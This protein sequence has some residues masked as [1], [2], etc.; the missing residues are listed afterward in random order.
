MKRS[1]KKLLGIAAALLL[2]LAVYAAMN[3]LIDPFGLFGD[4][5]FNWYGYNETNNPQMAKI[6]WLEKY[7]GGFDSYVIGSP[8]ASSLNA[9]ELNEYLD[10]SF[11]NLFT[12]SSSMKDYRD[13]TVY[14]L[15]NH[16][17]KNLVLNLNLSEAGVPDSGDGDIHYRKHAKVTGENPALFYM[18]YAF[19]S[20]RYAIDK[21][22]SC[23][24]DTLLPQTFDLFDAATGCYDRRIENVEKIG[25]PAVYLEEHAGA[26]EYYGGPSVQELPCLDECIQY[27]TE[28][29]DLCREKGVNLLVLCT[30][31]YITQLEAYGTEALARYKTALAQT[32][33]F[34][35]FSST[36]LSCDSRYFYDTFHFRDAVGTMVLAEVF[37]NDAVYR[38]DG[39]G[40][41]ITAGNNKEASR[42]P[43]QD[44]HHTQDVP[45]LMYHHFSE[46]TEGAVKPEE[47]ESH[48]QALSGAGY[49]PVFFQDL[50]DYVYHGI[51]LPEKPVCITFDDGYLSNYEIA[52]PLLELYG[53]KATIFAIGCSV[54][55]EEFYK[56]TEFR[57][58]PHFSYGQAREMTA[59]GAIDIQSHTYD[60]HQW[61][62]F[63]TGNEIR[64]SALPLP[65]ETEEAYAAALSADMTFYNRLRQQELNGDFCALAYPGGFYNTLTE[66]LIHEN[67]IP[68]T[69]SIKTDCRNVLVR[70]LPQSLYALCRWNVPAGMTGEA[71]VAMIQ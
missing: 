17:V 16:T 10:A 45:V 41:L 43:Q 12:Y 5:V 24:Q 3:M 29:R 36:S 68:V 27:L 51:N 44:E 22:W 32:V 20:P 13:Y 58:T 57:L 8:C 31:V 60:M 33:D 11:Y 38:P 65:G 25:D 37:G 4:P 18:R 26:F 42:L 56:D 52:W 69:L 53:M 54:G 7:G 23:F 14:L 19:C 6:A 34:W 1:I 46:D 55:H 47:L 15:N 71:V 64:T 48:L 59:S 67:G 40:T 63:E 21:V 62:E 70:G 50:I 49:T 61:E 30:P 2:A 9:G 66:V 28:I 35:D 39:F